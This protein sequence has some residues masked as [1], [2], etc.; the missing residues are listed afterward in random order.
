MAVLERVGTSSLGSSPDHSGQK[1]RNPT[2]LQTKNSRLRPILQSH[3]TQ[4]FKQELSLNPKS[5]G[6][7]ITY[8][9]V[10]KKAILSTTALE[11]WVDRKSY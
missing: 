2:S 7:S 8:I 1:R 10:S 3:Y 5:L 9:C 11:L 6:W 4:C